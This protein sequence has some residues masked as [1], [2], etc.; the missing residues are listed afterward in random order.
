MNRAETPRRC[1]GL[2][3]RQFLALVDVT[4]RRLVDRSVYDL[5]DI[6]FSALY[7]ANVG[8]EGAAWMAIRATR[9]AERSD[10]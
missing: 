5:I 10:R 3:F 1:D 8:A 6:D 7:D 9:R 2:T 4:C